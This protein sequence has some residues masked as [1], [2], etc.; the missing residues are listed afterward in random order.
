MKIYVASSWRN[1]YQP[2]V[3]EYFRDQGH[4]VYDFRNPVSGDKGFAWSDLDPNWQQ[5]TTKEYNECLKSPIAEAGFKNDFSN[6]N[7]ADVCVLVLPSG[8]SAHSEAGFMA[9]EKK[10]VFVYAPQKFEPELM[11]KMFDGVFEFIEDIEVELQITKK[12]TKF[13]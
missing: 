7:W 12:L 3:V 11:Y 10:P 13:T 8:S 4:E 1:I 5:W 6:M 2:M 9:G